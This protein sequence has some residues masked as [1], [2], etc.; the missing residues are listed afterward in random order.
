MMLRPEPCIPQTPHPR[1]PLWTPLTA[2][3]C[4][5]RPAPIPSAPAARPHCDD[6]SVGYPRTRITAVN[7]PSI[8]EDLPPASYFLSGTHPISP[9]SL[10]HAPMRGHLTCPRAVFTM[11][12]LVAWCFSMPADVVAGHAWPVQ[13][14]WA[15]QEPALN[16]PLSP[17]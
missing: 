9:R 13:R 1:T 2:Q 6:P 17:R 10:F 14:E 12:T 3:S 11:Q 7:I 8:C 15:P 5:P 4:V 16:S